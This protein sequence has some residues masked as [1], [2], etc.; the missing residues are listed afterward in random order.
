MVES[1]SGPSWATVTRKVATSP[2]RAEASDAANDTTGNG[3]S[4]TALIWADTLSTV[5]TRTCAPISPPSV[6][7]VC[8]K[9]AESL[10]TA[11]GSAVPWPSPGVN[12]TVAPSTGEPP[13]STSR[14]TTGSGNARPTRARW[15]DPPACSTTATVSSGVSATAPI[16]ADTLSTAATRTW[17]PIAPPSVQAVCA[18]PAESLS[19]TA[20]SAVPWPSPGVNVTVAPSTGEPPASTSR[21]TT[22]SGSTRPTL[23]RWSD[24]PACRSSAGACCTVTDAVALSPWNEAVTVP[25][26]LPMEVAVP[27]AL[28]SNTLGSLPDQL[29]TPGYAAPYWSAIVAV[30]VTVSAK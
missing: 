8:A 15:S 18:K 3:R 16:W 12:V 13:A 25:C 1:K 7:A 29:G 19:T 2:S 30:K 17:A 4:P 23:A 14:T 24:P 11:A 28:I 5:A 26:P 21:T 9:P 10:S 6:Q 22:G 27:P 20:G